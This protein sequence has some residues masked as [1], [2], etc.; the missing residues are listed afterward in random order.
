VRATAAGAEPV[1][2]TLVIGRREGAAARPQ[3]FRLDEP[4]R[5]YAPLAQRVLEPI[6]PHSMEMSPAR[7]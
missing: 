7:A 6:A 2:T 4:P 3:P 5:S 1:A